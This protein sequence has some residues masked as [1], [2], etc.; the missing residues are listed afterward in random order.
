[1]LLLFLDDL[2]SFLAWKGTFLG[3]PK[4]RSILSGRCLARLY[5]SGAFSSASFP[6]FAQKRKIF[7]RFLAY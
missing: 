6:G 3:S 1:M 2:W 5:I 4:L 7:G